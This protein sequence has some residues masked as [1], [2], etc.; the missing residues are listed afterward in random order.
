MSYGITFEIVNDKN[1]DVLKE[2]HRET[3]NGFVY[4]DGSYRAMIRGKYL[5][6]YLAKYENDFV[7]QITLRWA[8]ESGILYLY[9][10]SV[11]VLNKFRRKGFGHELIQRAIYDSNGCPIFLHVN[12]SNDPAINLYI[13]SGFQSLGIIKDFYVDGDAFLMR[14]IDSES[15][16]KT[17]HQHELIDFLANTPQNRQRMN[18]KI[19]VDYF[20]DIMPIDISKI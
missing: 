15:K 17:P 14:R 2:I 16:E 7:G 12:T 5:Y 19:S 20:E 11:S 10:I 3:H 6:S 13:K 9:I 18:P 8:L 1:C 4:K